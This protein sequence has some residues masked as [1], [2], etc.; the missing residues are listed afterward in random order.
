MKK[1]LLTGLFIGWGLALSGQPISPPSLV[2]GYEFW[3]NNLTEGKV[4]QAVTP[5]A[6]FELNVQADATHLPDGLNIL[7]LRFSDDQ[8]NWSSPLSRFFVKMPEQQASPEPK[9]IVE[10]EY[11]F[12]NQ[13]PTREAVTPATLHITDQELSAS[14][15]PDGLNTFTMRFRADPDFRWSPPPR[16]CVKRLAR[17]APPETSNFGV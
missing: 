4:T 14:D 17:P 7:T 10:Q 2:T 15:L 3:F 9:N 16:C 8:G 1:Y 6:V 5:S 11:W 12:N 13:P